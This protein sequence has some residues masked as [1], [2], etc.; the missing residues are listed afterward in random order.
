MKPATLDDLDALLSANPGYE[1]AMRELRPDLDLADDV[2]ALRVEAGF[3]Q[4]E[5]AEIVGTDQA[6]ISRLESARAN[7]TLKFLKRVA[8]ALGAEVDVRLR[9]PADLAGSE[10]MEGVVRSVEASLDATNTIIATEMRW[11]RSPRHTISYDAEVIVS[12]SS[13]GSC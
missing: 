13:S 2:I 8:R 4:A 11:A 12:T 1:V 9:R 7:P 3:S 6:N 5:L 10:T